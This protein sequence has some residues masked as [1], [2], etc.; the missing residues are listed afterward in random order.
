ML[1]E[2]RAGR[3]VA[4][5]NAALAGRTSLDEAAMRVC[6][7]DEPH[8]VTGLPGQD[9]MVSLTVALGV[10][11]GLGAGR[12]LL[13]LPRPGDPL[14]LP[15]P[16]E[17]N[18]EALD[19]G[20]A[21]LTLGEAG[22]DGPLGLVPECTT[23]GPAGDTATR[24]LWRAHPV[25]PTARLDTPSLGEAERELAEALRE[26][27][28]ALTRLDVAN[29]RPELAE[30]L[31]AIRHHGRDAHDVLAPGYPPRAFRV[32]ALAQRLEAITTLAREQDGA[33]VSATQMAARSALLR[34][35][36]RAIARAQLA[37]YNAADL[38]R[39]G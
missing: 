17:F 2:R 20:E 7:Q 23:Y 8:R 22:Q 1:S 33:A 19:A 28:D 24:V 21:V 16:P 26:A 38:S 18:L 9:G 31:G 6:G 3:F 37:A 15:G 5:G 11:R 34:P 4:W 14:G 35:L 29:W 12:L 25:N 30:A 10:L 39:Q 13:A 36:E 32:L 27:T